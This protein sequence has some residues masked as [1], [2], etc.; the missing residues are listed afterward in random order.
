PNATSAQT[1]SASVTAPAA[2]QTRLVT[3]TGAVTRP[4]GGTPRV[5]T[6]GTPVGGTG[7]TPLPTLRVTTPTPTPTVLFYRYLAQILA[8]LQPTPTPSPT[9][10]GVPIV[11]TPTPPPTATPIPFPTNTPTPFVGSVRLLARGPVPESDLVPAI[12]YAVPNSRIDKNWSNY[13]MQQQQNSELVRIYA[14]ET[15]RTYDPVLALTRTDEWAEGVCMVGSTMVGVQ[16]WGDENDGWARVLVDGVER[17]R[18]NTYGR[19]PD[20]FI[21][22]LEV[23]DLKRAPHVIRVEPLGQPG[24]TLAGGNSH[25]SIYAVV[26]GM[27]VETEIFVPILQR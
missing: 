27:P 21:H 17:W 1:P 22:F 16:F 7:A 19:S 11:L 23:R 4:P 24:T 6:V 9:L 3:P 18:G 10:L 8:Q 12:A 2:V 14:S 26:C 20:L 5:A 25:V 13:Y 15:A